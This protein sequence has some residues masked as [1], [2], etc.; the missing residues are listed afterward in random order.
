M[1]RRELHVT[2]VL[3]APLGIALAKCPVGVVERRPCSTSAQSYVF[4]ARH[5]AD[6]DQRRR[7]GF[8]LAT[9]C[10]GRYKLA[11]WMAQ[12]LDLACMAS[13]EQREHSFKR[14]SSIA[15]LTSLL[16]FLWSR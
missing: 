7:K 13:E 5:E 6:N 16:L 4:L 1:T 15:Q 10:G 14:T 11:A 12:A 2:L 3:P 8:T 9:S